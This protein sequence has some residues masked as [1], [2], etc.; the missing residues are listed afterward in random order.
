MSE[1]HVMV[2]VSGLFTTSVLVSGKS[3][4]VDITGIKVLKSL[5]V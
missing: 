4:F 2:A 3:T 5:Q 1:S